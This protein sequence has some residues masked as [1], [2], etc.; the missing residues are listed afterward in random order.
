[1]K[2][3]LNQIDKEIAASWREKIK[4]LMLVL[5]NQPSIKSQRALAGKLKINRSRLFRWINGQA[6]LEPQSL[7]TMAR[8]LNCTLDQLMQYLEGKIYLSD[9]LIGFSWIDEQEREGN[10]FAI[11]QQ[12]PLL[13]IQ[14]LDAIASRIIDLTSNYHENTS[15]KQALFVTYPSLIAAE[16]RS[17]NWDLSDE[18]LKKIAASASLDVGRLRRIWYGL[19]PTDLDLVDLS[20]F[21][22]NPEGD[23]WS[24]EE[25]MQ[26]KKLSHVPEN[27][28]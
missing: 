5:L 22:K 1:M 28:F 18:G 23:R 14:E 10:L 25:L 19:E 26:I 4:D 7:E 12:L 9:F 20:R 13:S 6:S 21:L 11:L 27:T 16:I 15:G 24:I 17:N 8:S 3:N 2:L